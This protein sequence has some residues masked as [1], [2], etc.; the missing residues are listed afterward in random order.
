MKKASGRQ[1]GSLFVS[2]GKE[3][4]EEEEGKDENRNKE[5]LRL[6]PIYVVH[7]L[8]IHLFQLSYFS[9]GIN[10]SF[11]TLACC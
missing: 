2:L 4:S 11:S 1:V 6:L 10:C 3:R 8:G 9:K 7:R 5:N